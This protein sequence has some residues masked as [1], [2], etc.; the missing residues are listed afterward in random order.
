MALPSAV[1][2]VNGCG[3]VSE[4]LERFVVMTV[5]VSGEEVEH[6]HVGEVGQPATSIV[7]RGFL[8]QLTVVRINLPRRLTSPVVRS[9]RR[10]TSEM[11]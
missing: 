3:F 5:H 4:Q 10:E 11:T 9:V 7:W 8:N 2:K 6:R 1:I